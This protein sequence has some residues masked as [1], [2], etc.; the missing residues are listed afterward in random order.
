M[1]TL[2]LLACCVFTLSLMN[3]VLPAGSTPDPLWCCV[4]LLANGSAVYRLNG[5]AEFHH[6]KWNRNEVPI[7]DENGNAD[8]NIVLAVGR[9]QITLTQNYSGVDFSYLTEVKHTV[10]CTDPCESGEAD[11]LTEE[12]PET[13]QRDAA[14]GDCGMNAASQVGVSV[15]L[16][17]IAAVGIII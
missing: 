13:D 3:T 7:T 9:D 17:V 14:D 16:L 2:R 12:R 4:E 8:E 5:S 6:R 10:P 15:S 11:H 1:K